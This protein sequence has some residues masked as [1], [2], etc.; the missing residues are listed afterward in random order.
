MKAMVNGCLAVVCSMM[1][2]ACAVDSA[3][4]QNAGADTS[5][6][7]AD[8][9]AAGEVGKLVQLPPELVQDPPA[10]LE[11]SGNG[12]TTNAC[13]VVLEFCSD[14]R[15]GGI[16]SYSQ[17]GCSFPNDF[18]I[19]MSLCHSICGHIA[20]NPMECVNKGGGCP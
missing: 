5:S 7:S 2:A 13:H 18:N 6:T 4:D 1:F 11:I 8:L 16:P 17:T 14:S 3:P 9:S 10:D 20:C 19:A 12:A 15:F